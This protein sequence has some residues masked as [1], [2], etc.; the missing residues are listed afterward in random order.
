[1]G[2][3]ILSGSFDAQLDHYK[4]K[5]QKVAQLNRMPIKYV[6]KAMN[7]EISDLKEELLNNTANLKSLAEKIASD[8]K[9]SPSFNY[10]IAIADIAKTVGVDYKLYAG[11]ALDSSLGSSFSEKKAEFDEKV[12]T[13]EHPMRVNYIYLSINGKDYEYK[14]SIVH[15]DIKELS[16]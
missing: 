13:M 8:V 9:D 10:A 4:E 11:Y 15:L 3:G 1:M 6:M 5:F 12:K 14:D 16:L 2:E 7:C